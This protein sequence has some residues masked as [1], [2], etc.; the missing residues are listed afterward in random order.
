MVLNFSEMSDKEEN[1]EMSVPECNER[2]T[3]RTKTK[4]KHLMKLT[5]DNKIIVKY[6]DY[7]IHV[8]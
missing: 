2:P 7:K 5:P 1:K 4:K 6:N 8:G 3:K